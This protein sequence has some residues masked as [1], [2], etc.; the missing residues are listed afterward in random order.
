MEAQTE[1]L[2]QRLV[3]LLPRHG[4]EALEQYG[5]MRFQGEMLDVKFWLPGLCHAIS[6]FHF[7]CKDLHLNK[8]T[9]SLMSPKHPR[10]RAVVAVASCLSRS[11]VVAGDNELTG[12]GHLDKPPIIKLALVKPGKGWQS[13]RM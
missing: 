12:C 7:F 5:W 3:V 10:L 1:W 8:T 6:F 11:A 4:R 2:K 9:T 13:R